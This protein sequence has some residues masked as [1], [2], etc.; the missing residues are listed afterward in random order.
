LKILEATATQKNQGMSLFMH[1]KAIMTKEKSVKQVTM[2]TLV[3]WGILTQHAPFTN[4]EE[5]PKVIIKNR[6]SPIKASWW[7]SLAKSEAAA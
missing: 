5:A 6:K 2:P 3:K 1:A 4:L 7:K